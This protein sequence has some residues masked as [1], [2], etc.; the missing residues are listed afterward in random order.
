MNN[1][2]D[3]DV[4]DTALGPLTAVVNFDG[5][6]T[7]VWSSDAG[8]RLNGN[9]QY[10]RRPEALIE[11]R[12]QLTEYAAGKRTAFDLVLAPKGSPFQHQVWQQLLLIPFGETRTYGQLAAVLG[13]PNASRAVG[14]ANATNPIG[15]IVP[16]HRVIGASGELTG[17]AGGLPM[18]RKLL[19]LEGV[20]LP[21]LF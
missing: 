21:G 13:N 18:K 19:E 14:R 4:F 5:A 12:R 10:E 16:C 11:A 20:L 9:P 15:I 1:S 7:E 6:V 3:Y 2:F 17:Y 8:A